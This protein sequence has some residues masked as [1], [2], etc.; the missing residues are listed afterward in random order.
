MTNNGLWK[1]GRYPEASWLQEGYI[2]DDDFAYHVE[3]ALGRF[4]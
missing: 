3:A 2:N 4:F 1:D